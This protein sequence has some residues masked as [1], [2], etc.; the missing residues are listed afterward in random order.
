MVDCADHHRVAAWWADRFGV[1][2]QTDGE[3][4]WLE[5]GGGPPWELVFNAVPEP[6]RVKNRVHWDVYGS[7]AELLEAGATLVRARDDEIRWDQLARRGRQRVLRVR[8][9]R[10]VR[11]R[12]SLE[13]DFRGESD[14]WADAPETGLRCS[15]SGT[16]T[17]RRR[18][19]PCP[20]RPSSR[21]PAA[22]PP[23][24]G[25]RSP[26][27]RLSRLAAPVGLVHP[28]QAAPVSPAAGG[29][30][31]PPPHGARPRRG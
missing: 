5:G 21:R 1:D 14:P 27:S 29:P 2:V 31:R 22:P 17:L 25:R 19:C 8:A 4:V 10:E 20:R 11:G 24:A 30:T 13:C 26:R 15:G 9:R 12:R 28:A 18:S 23:C 3:N 16:P 7:T 6:K